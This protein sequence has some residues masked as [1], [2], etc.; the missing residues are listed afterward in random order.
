VLGS[1]NSHGAGELCRDFFTT[2]GY[3]YKPTM[4]LELNGHSRKNMQN[5]NNLFYSDF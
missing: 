2:N 5:D 4:D 1:G 3:Q